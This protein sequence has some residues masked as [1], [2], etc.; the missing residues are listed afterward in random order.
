M[1][2]AWTGEPWQFYKPSEQDRIRKQAA[3][4]VPSGVIYRIG[5]CLPYSDSRSHYVG[6]LFK[7]HPNEPDPT[8]ADVARLVACVNACEGIAVPRAIP[9]LLRVAKEIAKA[10]LDGELTPKTLNSERFQQALA[11]LNAI[12]EA[13]TNW[14]YDKAAK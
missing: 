3:E 10:W 8:E 9:H 7:S 11:M 4:Y 2:R 12:T 1:E 14:D 5:S 6:N 13:L